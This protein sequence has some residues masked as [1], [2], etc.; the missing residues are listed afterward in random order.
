MRISSPPADGSWGIAHPASRELIHPLTMGEEFLPRP[1]IVGQTDWAMLESLAAQHD[2]QLPGRWRR[3]LRRPDLALVLTDAT[4]QI[5]WVNP[6]FT[7]MSGYPVA[8]V[9]GRRPG[10]LQGSGTA[11]ETRQAIR[12][13][14]RQARPFTG[15]LLNY[16]RS[17]QP[18]QC[19]VCIRPVRN[20]A[21]ILTHFLA[22]EHEIARTTQP[23]PIEIHHT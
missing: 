15:T 22:F 1:A 20:T 14:L 17:G 9:L 13:R 5:C 19:W 3:E 7:R 11:E 16:R 23:L 4:Q 18:Y 21:G 2:W 8:D 6:G 10:F 12:A